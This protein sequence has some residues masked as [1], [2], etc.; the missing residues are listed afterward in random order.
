MQADIQLVDD[1]YGDNPRRQVVDVDRELFIGAIRQRLQQLQ[2]NEEVQERRARRNEE[3]EERRQ[4][5][6]GGSEEEQ[7]SQEEQSGAGEGATSSLPSEFEREDGRRERTKQKAR[8]RK[9][10]EQHIDA[11]VPHDML[12]RLSPLLTSCGVSHD[13]SA[14]IVA[15]FYRECNIE[16]SDV[17]LSVASSKRIRSAEN[18][19]VADK[20][21]SKLSTEVADKDIVLTLHFDTKQLEQRMF[22]KVVEEEEERRQ[23]RR[24]GRRRRRGR[25]VQGVQ[26]EEEQQQGGHR[27]DQQGLEEEVQAGR[28][29]R[30]TKDRLAIVVTGQELECEHLLCVPGLEGGTAV[31]QADALY[32]VLVQLNLDPY[33]AS[34]VYDTTATNT[35]RHGGVVRLIQ[36]RLGDMALL[37][38]PCR[39]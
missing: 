32:A 7:R 34:L 19:F 1:L 33:V 13:N 39:R 8:K 5:R 9:I 25:G 4:A 3:R 24:Q 11:R 31:E 27:Q 21:I 17:V 12:R 29:V 22:V 37:C 18:K 14:K 38:C 26:E 6:E 15:A 30:S 20:A 35:G 2:E 36:E 16:L 28:L 23:V 10:R